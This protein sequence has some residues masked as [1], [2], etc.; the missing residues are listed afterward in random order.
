MERD[1]VMNAIELLKSDHRT[2]QALFEQEE[3]VVDSSE[4]Q[5]IF[6]KIKQEFLIHSEIEETIFYPFF[7]EDDRLRGLV[8]G[9]FDD[10][11]EVKDLLSEL[12]SIRNTEE[13][14]ERFGELVESVNA[15]IEEEENELFPKIQTSCNSEEL[16]RIG[17][18][19]QEAKTSLKSG[20]AA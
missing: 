3:P 13:F 15:H 2:V 10:H 17:D 14:D 8:E 19:L 1:P 9:F 6:E 7:S 4:R 20:R 5:V 18:K 12:D 11:Q 16:E